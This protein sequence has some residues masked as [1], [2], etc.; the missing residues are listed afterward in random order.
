V[1]SGAGRGLAVGGALAVLLVP[2][3]SCGSAAGGGGTS[4]PPPTGGT[5]HYLSVGGLRRDYYEHVPK[6]ASSSPP[7]VVVLHGGGATAAGTEDNSGFDAVADRSG[8]VAVYPD[9]YD[10]SWADGRGQA[11]ADKA[12]VDDVAFLAGVLADVERRNHVDP[13]R[14]FVTGISNGGFMALTFACRRAELVAAVAPNAGSMATSVASSCAPSQP[15]SVMDIHGTAD[16]LVPYRGGPMHSR[17]TVSEI[18]SQ[19]QVLTEWTRLDGCAGVGPPQ[20]QPSTVDDGTSLVI[21]AATGCPVGTS[22]ALWTVVGGGHTWPGGQQY[23]PVRTIGPVSHQFS[24]P[25]KIWQFF[26]A[27]GR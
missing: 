5:L 1:T 8:F 2:L 11:P 13:E 19:R 17:G 23:L 20:R 15:V 18:V 12:G 4:A 9:G 24:A 27:H 7:V 16:P 3:A 26:A 6:S 21:T 25:E 10:N 14:V 22:V